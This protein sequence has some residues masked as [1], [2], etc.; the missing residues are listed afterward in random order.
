MRAR[1]RLKGNLGFIAELERRGR[2]R[3]LI[4]KT[5]VLTGLRKAELPSLTVGQCH[6]DGETPCLELKAGD[7]KNRQ[8]SLLPLRR[9]LADELR[10][11]IA[12]RDRGTTDDAVIAFPGAKAEPADVPL[13]NVPAGLV[14]ILDR[15]LKAA[16]IPKM[17]ERGR[18]VDVHA[19]RH[20]FET[21]LSKGGGT[22]DRTGGDASQPDRPDDERLHG[23]EAIGRGGGTRRTAGAATGRGVSPRDGSRDRDRRRRG[24]TNGCTK[25]GATVYIG[26]NC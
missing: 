23:P 19:L 26:G 12:S 6:L 7:E 21:L 20:T 17:D 4:Y 10:E 16:E 24:C 18:T 3:A 14:R 11:W 2:E 13:F 1:K 25:S 9:D 22:A 5:F 8:G 15:D